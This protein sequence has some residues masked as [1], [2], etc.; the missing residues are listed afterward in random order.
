METTLADIAEAYQGPAFSPASACPVCAGE[1]RVAHRALNIHPNKPRRFDLRVCGQCRHGWID[2]MPSQGLLNY[3][4]NRGSYSVVGA[5]WTEAD[6]DHLTLPAKAVT[7]RELGP[8]RAVGR[9]FEVG[10]GKGSLYRHFLR[11]GWLCSGVEPGPW[12]RGLPGVE[13]DIGAVPESATAD[14]IAAL[15]VLEHVAD[16]IGMLRKIRRFAA[17]SA[18]LY[19]AM[20]NRQSVRAIL[21]RGRWRMMRPLGH[22]NYWSRD[23]V[24]RTVSQAGFSV[25]ELRKTDLWELRRI[26]GVRDAVAAAIEHLGFGDQWIVVA[27]ASA[28]PR[29]ASPRMS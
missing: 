1:S 2:P 28:Q 10:V 16:P 6:E 24:V 27:R 25:E 14:V 12:G 7:A 23:S 26:R 5:D 8:G 9:F 19:C 3:L 18:R 13:P 15:D 4:Y 22:V 21:G 17:P 11:N 20:P 29:P